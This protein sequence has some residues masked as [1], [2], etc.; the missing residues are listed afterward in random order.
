[1]LGAYQPW[2]CWLA[3]YCTT[4]VIFQGR[5]SAAAG[6][7]KYSCP[8]AHGGAEYVPSPRTSCNR[9]ACLSDDRIIL[10][11]AMH[12]ELMEETDACRFA[13]SFFVATRGLPCR[14][15]DIS[16]DISG[17]ARQRAKQGHGRA[18]GGHGL[19]RRSRHGRK[20]ELRLGDPSLVLLLGAIGEG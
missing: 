4:R 1:M 10:C 9:N 13:S 6:R 16:W 8:R 20:G 18:R 17:Y 5:V 12:A 14:S 3:A 2:R 11:Q 15:C 7:L 19:G